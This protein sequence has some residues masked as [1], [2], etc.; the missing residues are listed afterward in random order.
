[1]ESKPQSRDAKNKSRALS[2]TKSTPP[3]FISLSS[4]DQNQKKA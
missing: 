3:E 1:M 2:T 4:L